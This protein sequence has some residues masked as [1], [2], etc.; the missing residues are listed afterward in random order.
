MRNALDIA[1]RSAAQSDTRRPD[2]GPQGSARRRRIWH[3]CRAGYAPE[4]DAGKTDRREWNGLG[5]TAGHSRAGRFVGSEPSECRQ[6]GRERA[7]RTQPLHESRRCLQTRT[8]MWSKRRRNLRH[9]GFGRLTWAQILG[10]SI[11]YYLTGRQNEKRW[12]GKKRSKRQG[13]KT[14]G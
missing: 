4:V 3:A 2:R 9:R 6:R 5:T 1:G 11:S 12:K 14:S 8:G 10:S 13:R 7:R